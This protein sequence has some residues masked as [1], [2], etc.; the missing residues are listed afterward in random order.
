MLHV[1]TFQNVAMAID[2]C[3]E[4]RVYPFNLEETIIATNYSKVASKCYRHM[5]DAYNLAKNTNYDGF[6]WGFVTDSISPTENFSIYER[7]ADMLG[8]DDEDLESTV[9]MD[10]VIPDDFGL[11]SD[12]YYWTDY[13]CYELASDLSKSVPSMDFN[14]LK[15]DL[16]NDRKS[17]KQVIFPYIYRPMIMDIHMAHEIIERRD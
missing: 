3:K 6:F 16:F 17:E 10:L 15:D 5:Y 13:V 8:L 11:V 1:I 12:F 14:D 7:I 9:I 4:D 2:F